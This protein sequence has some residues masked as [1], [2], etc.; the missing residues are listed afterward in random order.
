[1]KAST[2]SRTARRNKTG[3]RLWAVAVW[4][5]VW[6]LAAILLGEGMFMSSPI[7]VLQNI[8]AMWGTP[9]FWKELLLGENLF[10]SSPVTVIVRLWKMAGTADFWNRVLF[11][12]VRVMGGLLLGMGAGV[13]LG[14]VSFFCR[15]LRE[16]LQPMVSVIRAVPVASFIILAL[17]WLDEESLSVFITFL[18]CFP[19][20]YSGTLSGFGGADERLLEMSRVFRLPFRKKL[21]AVYLPAVIRQT[22][23]SFEVA[24][25][26]AWKSGV[27]AEVIAIPGGSIGEKL[28][29]AKLYL[30]NGDML[31]WTL[32]IALL[33][34]GFTFLIK[35]VMR[36]VDRIWGDGNE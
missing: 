16:L 5:I 7:R 28:Y 23:A 25:G 1:M 15:R 21:R 11:S 24:V 8:R 34:G 17:L 14:S 13:L 6:Q 18:I 36:A 27:A 35:T 9:G 31:A 33:S 2:T 26:L 3:L 22:T 12:T 29:R 4:L 20:F 19:V 32:A 10:L 30:E